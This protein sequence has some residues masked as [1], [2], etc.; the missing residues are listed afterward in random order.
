MINVISNVLDQGPAHISEN[1]LQVRLI[2]ASGECVFI[3]HPLD[4]PVQKNV[5]HALR[6]NQIFNE[7]PGLGGIKIFL[8]HRNETIQRA[9]ALCVHPDVN[10]P[11]ILVRAV[12]DGRP[13]PAQE[14]S[15]MKRSQV[16]GNCV[17]TASIASSRA[18]TTSGVV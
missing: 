8:A 9:V 2:I 5:L 13:A 1:T 14:K 3:E 6:G 12:M 11:S 18:P 16:P 7:A 10:V 17:R 15:P 4:P